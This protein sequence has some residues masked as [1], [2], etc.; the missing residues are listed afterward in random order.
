MV[1]NANRAAHIIALA[2]EQSMRHGEDLDHL[3]QGATLSNSRMHGLQT[4]LPW[5]VSR[6]TPPERLAHFQTVLDRL[7]EKTGDGRGAVKER[8][9]FT[10]VNKL[11]GAGRVNQPW[12]P[13][14]LSALHQ[15]GIRDGDIQQEVDLHMAE[16]VLELAMTLLR[17]QSLR[18]AI[19]EDRGDDLWQ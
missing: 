10:Y 16:A 19:Y 3:L 2:R 11:V 6:Q 9:F 17:S 14:M 12:R 8:A 1:V 13:E 7:I 15:A 4:S 5:H 18:K